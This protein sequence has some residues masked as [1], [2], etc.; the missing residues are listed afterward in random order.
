MALASSPVAF[1][2]ILKSLKAKTLQRPSRAAGPVPEVTAISPNSAP[3]GGVGDLVISGRNFAPGFQIRI[4]CRGG[5]AKVAS[6][7]VE[8][9]ARAVAHVEFPPK[10]NLGPC[11]LYT[12]FVRASN[13]EIMPSRQGT[14]QVT[15]VKSVAFG[16][17]NSSPMDAIVGEYT[18]VPAEEAKSMASMQAQIKSATPGM[19]SKA[20]GAKEMADKYKKG[21]I[22]LAQLMAY[23]QQMSQTMMPQ[24][25]QDM[26]TG[27]KMAEYTK[28]EKQG[29]LRLRAGSLQFAAGNAVAFTESASSLKDIGLLGPPDGRSDSTYIRITFGDGKEYYFRSGLS[30]PAADVQ[31][32][33]NRLGK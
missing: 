3:Q 10:E 33:K 5:S 20:A 24:T 30:S 4:D 29:Q 31:W 2:Q 27:Q 7:K 21:E 12:D 11:D 26:A 23:T 16:I 17:S 18:L 28:Q 14:P 22:T 6:F 15:Q 25:Q 19:Q 13:G 9:S 1:T 8:S 32:L